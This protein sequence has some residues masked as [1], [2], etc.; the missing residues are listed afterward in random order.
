MKNIILKFTFWGMAALVLAGLLTSC[1]QENLRENPAEEVLKAAYSFYQ[2]ALRAELTPNYNGQLNVTLTRTNVAEAATVDVKLTAASTV[3]TSL[4]TLNSTSVSFAAGAGK[5]TAVVN[6][7]LE[8]LATDGS[9]YS[10][11]IGFVNAETPLSIGASSVTAVTA[12]RKLTYVL[13]DT[14]GTFTSNDVYGAAYLV[15]IERCIEAPH[16]Y[17]ALSLY[18]D[19]Y[20]ILIVTNPGAQ[21]AKIALQE[22]GLALFGAAYP[23]TWL[24]ADA[25]TFVDGVITVTPGSA[26]NYNRWIVEPAPST[27]GAWVGAPEILRL[28]AG[29]Y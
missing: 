8:S 5:A 14:P 15:D 6:F 12:T 28:P 23:Q 3:T 13:L 17:R 21:T 27:L 2:P 20:D 1:D 16:I 25:C 26:T 22:I 29:A 18:E 7:D 11:S 4:F 19:D 24:R 10:F 9:Q